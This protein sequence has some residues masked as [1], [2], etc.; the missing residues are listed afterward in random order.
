MD[1]STDAL[2]I[3]IGF[4]YLL[5]ANRVAKDEG[6]VAARLVS[7]GLLPGLSSVATLLATGCADEE[8][9]LRDVLRGSGIT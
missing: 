4:Q 9:R 8:R 5:Y 2:A 3:V 6:N 1:E 7:R